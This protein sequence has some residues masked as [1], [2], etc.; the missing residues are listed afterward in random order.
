M[1]SVVIPALNA[2]E[3]LPATIVSVRRADEI[4]VADG[5]STDATATVAQR[6]GARVWRSPR[7]RGLQLHAG[8]SAARG[9]WL[10]FVH[11]DTILGP[12]WREAADRHMREHGKKAA[13]LHLR[14]DSDAWQARLVEIGVALRV[15]IFGLPYGDQGLLISRELYDRIGG[16]RPI[17]LMEDVDLVRRLGRSRIAI[18]AACATTSAERWKR[19]GWLSRSARNLACLLLFSLGASPRRIARLY[20]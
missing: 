16:F 15:R 13:C 1:L 14:L 17:P 7:G 12:Q 20:G 6:E 11:A 18:L 9:D 4:L 2:A 19:N 8:A 5:G 3:T 10:L